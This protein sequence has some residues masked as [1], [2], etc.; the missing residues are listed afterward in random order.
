V[1]RRRTRWYPFLAELFGVQVG[2]GSRGVLMTA[3]DSARFTLDIQDA[4][5]VEHLLAQRSAIDSELE[6]IMSRAM[7]SSVQVS[8][9]RSPEHIIGGHMVGSVYIRG[10]GGCGVYDIETMLCEPI[11]CDQVPG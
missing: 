5:R 9:G 7:K 3:V 1:P 6:L 4:R 11:S 10:E 2:E 8:I